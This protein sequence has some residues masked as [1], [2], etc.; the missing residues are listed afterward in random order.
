MQHQE[1]KPCPF[2]QWDKINVA[3]CYHGYITKCLGCGAMGPFVFDTMLYT[4]SKSK[5]IEAWNSR[6]TPQDCSESDKGVK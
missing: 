6:K 4:T 5:A 3:E 1:I 2:C